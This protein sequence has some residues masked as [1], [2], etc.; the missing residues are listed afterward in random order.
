MATII[1]EFLVDARPDDVW[2]AVRDF[3]AVDKRLAPGFVTACRLDGD[4]RIVTFFNGLVAR[5]P[6]VS[7]DEQRRRLVYGAA[8]G[9]TTHY[10]AAVQLFAEGAR[11]TRFVWIVDLLPNELAEPIGAMAE[12]GAAT[13][14]RTLEAGSR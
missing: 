9:R 2:D 12:Q 6:L 10:N 3:G 5:E 11:R 1:K 13:M 4:A 7:I 8:G 14:K